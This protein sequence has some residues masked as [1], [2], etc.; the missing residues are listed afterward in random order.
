[1]PTAF[2]S[3][4]PAFRTERSLAA[5]HSLRAVTG[6]SKPTLARLRPL[7]AAA[8]REGACPRVVGQIHLVTGRAVLV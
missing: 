8:G 2:E 5:R 3:I 6:P 7:A 4:L 1:M